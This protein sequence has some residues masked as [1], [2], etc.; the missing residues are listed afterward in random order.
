M[1]GSSSSYASP[2]VNK[3]KRVS[4]Y[5]RPADLSPM[6]NSR[7]PNPVLTSDHHGRPHHHHHEVIHG[8]HHHRHSPSAGSLRGHHSSNGHGGSGATDSMLDIAAEMISVESKTNAWLSKTNQDQQQQQQQQHQHHQQRESNSANHATSTAI[9]A[10][11]N[12]TSNDHM[13]L[14]G[15]GS[16]TTTSTTSSSSSSS[17]SRFSRSDYL[18]KFVKITNNQ[19]RRDYKME[20][21]KDYQ[22]YMD[23]HGKVEQV[24]QRFSNLQKKLSQ[25]PKTSP[26]YKVCCLRNFQE[27]KRF[28]TGLKI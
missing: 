5:V 27:K 22:R 2:P 8:S 24:S 26:D 7:S 21:N 23:L 10:A 17:N 19:Q 6:S 4:N 18:A 11:I 1:N 14:N 3:K 28:Y 9:P 13:D 16:S 15:S 25:T 20:F 12:I